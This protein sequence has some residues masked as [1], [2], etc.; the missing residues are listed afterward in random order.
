MSDFFSRDTMDCSP[1]GSSVRGIS[2]AKILE[3]VVIFSDTHTEVTQSCL[4]LCDPMDYSLPDSS[5]HGIF[6]AWTLEW[7]VVSFSRGSSG[8]RDR[9]RVSNIIGRRF[10]VCTREVH[11][12]CIAGGFFTT[13]PPW[14]RILVHNSS[15]FYIYYLKSKCTKQSSK[16]YFKGNTKYK[17]AVCDTNNIKRR[18]TPETRPALQAA[19]REGP[20]WHCSHA[21]Y[22]PTWPASTPRRQLQRQ[23]PRAQTQAAAALP[24]P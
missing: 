20:T 16:T 11:G 2:Q 17:D 18:D 1:P 19:H 6:Q 8:P 9:T 5:V 14:K 21:S 12:S 13:Q 23:L 3:W 10:T 15:F 7:V 22:P 4:T 24:A